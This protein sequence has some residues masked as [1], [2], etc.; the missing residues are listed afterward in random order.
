MSKFGKIPD[1]K[2]RILEISILVFGSM[3]YQRGI[4][5]LSVI[6]LS[7]TCSKSARDRKVHNLP[8]NKKTGQIHALFLQLIAKGI[9][10]YDVKDHTKIGTE[11]LRQDD[12]FLIC[13]KKRVMVEGIKCCRP[14]YVV[15]SMWEGMN[16]MKFPATESNA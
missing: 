3:F 9:I 14:G 6:Y 13:P 1:Q 5:I 12:L 16:L 15:D 2:C 4:H 10:T 7:Q 8:K 11:K